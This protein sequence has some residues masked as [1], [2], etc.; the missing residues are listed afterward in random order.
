MGASAAGSHATGHPRGTR[1]RPPGVW[2][3]LHWVTRT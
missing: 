2:L 3:E 1:A